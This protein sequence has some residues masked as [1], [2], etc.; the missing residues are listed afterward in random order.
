M[1]HQNTSETS[2]AGEPTA[3]SLEAVRS[4]VESRDLEGLAQE[5][6]D[7]L[8]AHIAVV[9]AEG[10]IVRVNRAWREFANENSTSLIGLC[11][12]AN[13]LAV[14]ENAVGRDAEYG[15]P[16]AAAI[17]S[18]IAGTAGDFSADYPCHSADQ[19][20]WFTACIT[21]TGGPGPAA[22]AV[23]SHHEITALHVAQA[24]LRFQAHLLK[25]SGEAVIATDARGVITYMNDFAQNLYGWPDGE[26]IGR[27][28][29]DVTVP[30][31]GRERGTEILRQL[32]E[33]EKWSG[34]FLVQRRNGE[35]FPVLATNAPVRDEEGKLVAIISISKDISRQEADEQELVKRHAQL[36]EAEALACMGSWDWDVAPDRLYWSDE[37]F[38]MFEATPDKFAGDNEAFIHRI[39]PDDRE[40]IRRGLADALAGRR[41]Y[42]YE[43]RILLSDGSLR[44]LHTRGRVAADAAGKP[45][46]MFGMTQDI[47]AQSEIQMQL[48]AHAARL[49]EVRE[50]EATRIARE[51]HDQMGQ[52]LTAL[53]MDVAALSFDLK[54]REDCAADGTLEARIATM[55]EAIETTLETAVKLCTELRPAV[56]DKLGLV[57]TIEWAARDFEA[58]S[59]I[60]CNLHLPPAL[61]SIEPARATA[62]F[63]I[64]QEILT[65]VIRHAEAS[66]VTIRLTAN[67]TT[68]RLEVSD[69]GAGLPAGEKALES[70]L[71]I[72]GMRERAL[73]V[74]GSIDLRGASGGG[75]LVCVE[76][77]NG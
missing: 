71:G 16:F 44:M 17:R 61:G 62:I 45:I 10:E 69:N 48:R 31:A 42:D 35:V 13:Y 6:L 39:H 7:A 5:T 52:A 11:E 76:V 4:Q 27:H 34:Q 50:E 23:V 32:Q 21:R 53:K 47:T 55:S 63:R 56:L 29:I 73:A 66:E 25:Q 74:G 40:R 49:I 15:P 20:R 77:P 30:R 22:L 37:L 12:G 2:G 54:S 26:A 57:D 60:F 38:R 58:R 65:N 8:T 18:V 1:N 24:S 51:I 41:P 46:R 64:F 70:G 3:G 68:L 28:V 36:L 67:K 14:C 72:I 9:N 43:F 59:G 33:G 75:T 19:K